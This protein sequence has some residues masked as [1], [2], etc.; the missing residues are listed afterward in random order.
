VIAPWVLA[1]A[2]AAAPASSSAA[3][4]AIPV[5][6]DLVGPGFVFDATGRAA[7]PRTSVS[8][9]DPDASVATYDG[10]ALADIVHAAGANVGDAVRGAAARAYLVVHAN[11]GYVAVFSLAELRGAETRCTPILADARDGSALA[12]TVGPLRVVA[13]C[14]LTHARWVR[15]V[16]SLSIVVVPGTET[17]MPDHH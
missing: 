9:T 11:D 6:G 15:G 8:G 3:V 1:A 5:T 16:V 10:V 7:L 2:L 13:P 12:A 4:P 17:A 14:D